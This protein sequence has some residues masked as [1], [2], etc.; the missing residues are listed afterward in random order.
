MM[1]KKIF[2]I[3]LSGIMTLSFAACGSSSEAASQPLADEEK[4]VVTEGTETVA[5]SVVAPAETEEPKEAET[6]IAATEE[7]ETEAATETETETEEIDP[8][9][10]LLDSNMGG[11][12]SDGE[13]DVEKFANDTGASWWA[14]GDHSFIHVYGDW[15]IQAGKDNENQDISFIIIGNWDDNNTDRGNLNTYSYI[16]PSGDDISVGGKITIPVESV[17]HL[18]DV[19]LSTSEKGPN[20]APDVPGTDFRAC[21][22]VDERIQY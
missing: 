4:S 2:A 14:I 11:Y 18:Y 20:A 17:I 7:V 21:D 10:A 15:F 22:P 16:F 3:I 6:E 12:I 19:F 8:M 9:E 5:E 13:F 1:K